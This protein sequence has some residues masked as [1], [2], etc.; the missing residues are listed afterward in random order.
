[1]LIMSFHIP[2]NF[3]FFSSHFAFEAAVGMNGAVWVRAKT[4]IDSIIIR[5]A[6]LNSEFLNDVQTE[7]MVEQLIKVAKKIKK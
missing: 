6:V 5:N 4:C 3:Q 1:M 2:L 7:A